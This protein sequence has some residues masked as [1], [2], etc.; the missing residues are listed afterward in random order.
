MVG[1]SDS[2]LEGPPSVQKLQAGGEGT[3]WGHGSPGLT[4]RLPLAPDDGRKLPEGV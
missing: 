4:A 2:G 1:G 3:L